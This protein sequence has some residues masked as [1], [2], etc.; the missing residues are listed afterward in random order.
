[1]KFCIKDL[2]VPSALLVAPLLE[3]LRLIVNALVG[4]STLHCSTGPVG[5]IINADL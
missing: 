2:G 1:M 5:S 4:G 3:N